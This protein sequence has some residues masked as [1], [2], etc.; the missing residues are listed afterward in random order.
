M[1]VMSP[2]HFY[3]PSI[4]ESNGKGHKSKYACFIDALVGCSHRVLNDTPGTDVEALATAKE[5]TDDL[6]N[7]AKLVRCEEEGRLDPDAFGASQYKFSDYS[8]QTY[9]RMLKRFV[10]S[11]G[12]SSSRAGPDVLTKTPYDDNIENPVQTN[13]RSENL[14]SNRRESEHHLVKLCLALLQRGLQLKRDLQT[15]MKYC[16]FKLKNNQATVRNAGSR[17]EAVRLIYAL[18]MQWFEDMEKYSGILEEEAK[19]A[20]Q[21]LILAEQFKKLGEDSRNLERCENELP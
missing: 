10:R 5:K 4:P 3:S 1:K 11:E 13:V 20:E 16:I 14:P 18:K 21:C 12:E 7:T 19:N 2:F 17:L 15:H 8:E 6:S 9:T